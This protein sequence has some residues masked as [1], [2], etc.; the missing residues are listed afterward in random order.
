MWHSKNVDDADVADG[1]GM[2]GV[3]DVSRVASPGCH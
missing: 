3:R 1:G 2:S